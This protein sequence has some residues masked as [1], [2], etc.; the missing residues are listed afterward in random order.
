MLLQKWIDFSAYIEMFKEE[1]AFLDINF[2]R[3]L[4]RLENMGIGMLVIFVII[5]VIILATVAINKIF[6]EKK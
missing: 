5:G 4:E 6:S 3:A 2:E 1:L